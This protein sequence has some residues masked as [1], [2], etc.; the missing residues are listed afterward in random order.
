MAEAIAWLETS[1]PRLDGTLH[2]FGTPW[3][4][5]D[6][7]RGRADCETYAINSARYPA[8]ADGVVIQNV[9]GT[10]YLDRFE[11]RAG[12]WAM[13]KRRNERVWT[14]NDPVAEDPELPGSRT[15]KSSDED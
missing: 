2:V 14:R 4:D 9:S 6:L 5:L 12:G 7:T 13:V 1:I 15:T 8:D 3:I 11:F 10:R